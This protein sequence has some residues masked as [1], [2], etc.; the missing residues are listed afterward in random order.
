[1]RQQQLSLGLVHQSPTHLGW[2]DTLA[3]PATVFRPH[4]GCADSWRLLVT[5]PYFSAAAAAAAVCS[6]V[7]LSPF[8]S[9]LQLAEQAV[10]LNLR[11]MRW[12]AAPDLDIPTL[13]ATRCLLLGE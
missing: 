4:V 9:P 3:T 6:V 2:S 13:A 10:D 1:M 8:M 11:L 12:R 5:L 7:D